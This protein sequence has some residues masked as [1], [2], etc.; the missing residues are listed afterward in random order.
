MFRELRRKRQALSRADCEAVLSRGT[1][2]V[3]ALA[4]DDGYPYAVPLSYLYEDGKLLFHCAKAGHKL[5]AV[6]RCDKASFCVID[7]DRVVPEEYTTYF[8][9]VIA[10]GRI[11]V[12]GDDGERR[13]AVERLA[14]KYHPGDTRENRNRYIDKEWAPLCM[15]E[16]TVEHLSGKQATELLQAGEK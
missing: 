14:L 11:R 9:S 15:L 16:M 3:L 1:S 13:S 6:A 10:F 4:G 8:R 12:I 7:Q 2:G 5:D